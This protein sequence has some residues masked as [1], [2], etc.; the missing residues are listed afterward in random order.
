M[1]SP[2]S[3]KL[4]ELLWKNYPGPSNYEMMKDKVDKMRAN[5][6]K[7]TANFATPASDVTV[8]TVDI[9]GTAAEWLDAPGVATDRVLLYLH[10]GG[11]VIGS[12]ATHRG[13]TA[14][15]SKAANC[16]VLSLDYRLA[17]EHV[18]PAAVEDA[19]KAYRWLLSQGIAADKITIAG[20]SAGGGL[21]LATLVALR[22]AGD[23]LPAAAIPISPWTD[24]EGTGESMKTKVDLDPMVEPGGLMGMGQIYMGGG[25][26]KQ[27]TASPLYADYK[28]LPPLLIQVGDL[29]TLL[30]DATRV[31]ASAEAA[32]VD[33]TLEV[34][35]DM[36][37]VW[38]LFAPMVPEGR[39]A[40]ARIGQFIQEQTA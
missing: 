4:L 34:W 25:D 33:T 16:R 14:S 10:G 32:G 8:T 30:D 28:G 13:L 40:I 12:I 35:P 17:P 7:A 27:P 31:A 20:D 9:D 1:A 15:L 18:Y 26:P 5:F 6:V 11:Y 39:E 3:K 38:H 2:E 19:T 23:T 37:H 21:T 22:D 29:E 24:M 36:V